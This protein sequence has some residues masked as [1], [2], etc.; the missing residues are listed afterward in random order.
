MGVTIEADYVVIG[1]GA[2][3]LAFTDEILTQTDAT[4]ALIDNRGRPGGHWT[5]AY[6]FVRLH[7]PSSFYGVNSAEL[8]SERIDETGWN[9][10]LAE[11]ASGAE[12]CAYFDQVMNRRFL[13]SGRVAYYPS[14][15][16]DGKQAVSAPSAR[17]FEVH[18]GRA[19]VDATWMKVSVPATHP[20]RFEVAPRV[21][22]IPPNQ[23]PQT[24]RPEGGYVIIGAGKTAFDAIV[25]L[26]GNFV[27]PAE[28]TW[29]V[30]RDSWLLNRAYTQPGEGFRIGDH[31]EI[32]AGASSPAEAFA[33]LEKGGYLLR[34]DPGVEATMY[35]CATISEAELAQLRRVENVVRQGR[36]RTITPTSLDLEGGK[37][38]RS[39]DTVYVNCSADG[40]ETRPVVPVFGENGITLQTL[41]GCQQ[42]FSAALVGKIESLPISMD[43]KNALAGV[44]PHPDTERDYFTNTIDHIM[45]MVRWAENPEIA[46]WLDASRLSPGSSSENSGPTP[47]VV[48]AAVMKIQQ[49]L[50]DWPEPS[51]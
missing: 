28:I 39:P 6:P 47:E 14:T 35:R 11:L 25:W 40:L 10:G 18:A 42:V 48:M 15:T 30:P 9:A 21:N 38:T 19:I 46:G 43:E 29:I 50:A 1:A 12:V 16:W 2:M 20:P 34:V 24:P 41:R 3:G 4:V 36:V 5:D 49:F 26:L 17:T 7:Q 23:L 37:L 32:I 45:N 44:I 27:D 51:A 22:I 8:G 13:P 31:L 33:G